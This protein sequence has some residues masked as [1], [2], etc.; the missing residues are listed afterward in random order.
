MTHR[1]ARAAF[2]LALVAA[3]VGL[4]TAAQASSIYPPTGSC[5]VSPAA[6][7]PGASLQFS[8]AANTFA[9]NETVT[10][11]ITGENG[12]GAA[13][14]AVKF[15]ISTASGTVRSTASG[16]LPETQITL[17]GN[18]SGVYNITA[19]SETS[20]GSTATVTSTNGTSPSADGSL[21]ITGLNGASLLAVWVGAGAL[22]LAGGVLAVT[23]AVRRRRS[24]AED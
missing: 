3:F 12:Q 22:V 18:A 5:T 15:A 8:C 7:T 11:T 14:G 17:P 6:I 4:P 2:A 13:I 23:A 10:I 24:H 21:P 19:V 16:A 9:A 20:A 1:T